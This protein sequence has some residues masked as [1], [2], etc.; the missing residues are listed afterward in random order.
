MEPGGIQMV[1]VGVGL[2][3]HQWR[4][5]SRSSSAVCLPCHSTPPVQRFHNA[6]PRRLF[7][8]LVARHRHH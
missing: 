6:K 1:V 5:L 3:N 4:V 7:I 2:F 8:H